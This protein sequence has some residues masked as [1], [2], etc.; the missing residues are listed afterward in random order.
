MRLSPRQPK[1]GACVPGRRLVGACLSQWAGVG[2][3]RQVARALPDVRVAGSG[4]GANAPMPANAGAL[5]GGLPGL[6]P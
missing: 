6:S 5:D 4:G 2:I 1:A 3:G